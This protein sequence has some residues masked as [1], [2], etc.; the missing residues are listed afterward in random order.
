[1]PGITI[2]QHA[3]RACE[4][5]EKEKEMRPEELKKIK[6]QMKAER[7]EVD[8]TFQEIQQVNEKL[9]ELRRDVQVY[10]RAER[11]QLRKRANEAAA[12]DYETALSHG[13]AAI[14]AS[15]SWSS[16]YSQISQAEEERAQLWEKHNLAKARY[17]A[18]R[19]QLD[20]K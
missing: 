9:R 13:R 17:R 14:R 11:H 6:R 7:A 4:A 20:E 18:L 5:Y 16:I 1:M 10:E 15:D 2:A 3:Q 19:G 12:G 8:F